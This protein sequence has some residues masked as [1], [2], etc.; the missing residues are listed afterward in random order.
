MS[1]AERGDGRPN[2]NMSE[3]FEILTQELKGYTDRLD[4]VWRTDL[5]AVNARLTSLKLPQINPKCT[6]AKG[7]TAVM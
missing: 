3:I 4:Q 2:N 5:A 7:C 6:D 1:M